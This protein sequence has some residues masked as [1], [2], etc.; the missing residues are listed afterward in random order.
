[1]KAN[2]T[3][4]KLSTKAGEEGAQQVWIWLESFHKV[5]ARTVIITDYLHIKHII[6]LG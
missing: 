1:M 6:C 4:I 3:K 5:T 2:K